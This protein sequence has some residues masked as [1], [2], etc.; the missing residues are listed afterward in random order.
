MLTWM[1]ATIHSAMNSLT[2]FV[3]LEFLMSTESDPYL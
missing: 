3:S 2:I 1:A